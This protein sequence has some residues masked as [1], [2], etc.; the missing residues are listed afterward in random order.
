MAVV[1][2]H[3]SRAYAIETLHVV[4]DR[5]RYNPIRTKRKEKTDE[6]LNRR[7][8][9]TIVD[10]IRFARARF[11]VLKYTAVRVSAVV[12]SGPEEKD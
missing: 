6:K 2:D 4:V 9:T 5:A 11:G 8:R 1:L 10:R 3:T 12:M 7:R